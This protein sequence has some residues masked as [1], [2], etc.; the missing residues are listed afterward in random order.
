V[1]NVSRGP[2]DTKDALGG[3]EN[4]ACPA[5]ISAHVVAV[6]VDR[7][8]LPKEAADEC[9]TIVVAARVD[10]IVHA[11]QP[12]KP[13]RIGLRRLDNQQLVS[14]RRHW[15]REVPW[16]EQRGDPWSGR[17][18]RGIGP[19][20]PSRRRNTRNPTARHFERESLCPDHQVDSGLDGAANKAIDDPLL[21]RPAV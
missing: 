4:R 2:D 11:D 8:I 18:K 10:L 15:H 12:G 3:C 14:V 1:A 19:D 13:C 7:P 16:I 9:S 17:E 20:L 5:V 6:R 21:V